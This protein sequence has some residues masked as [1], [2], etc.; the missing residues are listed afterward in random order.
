MAHLTPPATCLI[1]AI[2]SAVTLP[3]LH[4]FPQ[5]DPDFDFPNINRLRADLLKG[6]QRASRPVKNHK[7]AVHVDIAFVSVAIASIDS[8]LGSIGLNGILMISWQ[9]EHLRWDQ[10]A[11]GGIHEVSFSSWEIWTPDAIN[12]NSVSTEPTI[13]NDKDRCNIMVMPNGTVFWTPAFQITSN[14]PLDLTDF[15]SDTQMCYINYGMWASTAD[16]VQLHAGVNYK[17][18]DWH[19]RTHVVEMTEWKV[20]DHYLVETNVTE[21]D[22]SLYSGVVMGIKV[23]RNSNML[24]FLLRVPYYLAAVT[25]L[26]VFFL[27]PISSTQRISL[28]M[29]ALMLL[30]AESL[31]VNNVLITGFPGLTVPAILKSL[32]LHAFEIAFNLMI[33]QTA[34]HFIMS[35]KIPS[36]VEKHVTSLTNLISRYRIS[37]LVCCSLFA[38]TLDSD[39]GENG[40]VTNRFNSLTSGVHDLAEGIPDADTEADDAGLAAAFSSSNPTTNAAAKI[41]F[42]LAIVID[43]CLLLQYLLFL[44][45]FHA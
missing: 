34:Y 3:A 15:P 40:S 42:T 44:M 37:Q 28:T 12:W 35:T 27:T 2:I 25:E 4:A 45:I 32:E 19:V 39:F 20:L 29:F 24:H 1:L 26:A 21:L 10:A 11:Y 43:R 14:C 13:R 23:Q 30:Y 16:E 31:M 7:S 41:P 22:G 9:D 33:S 18:L 17:S 38:V 6:Y 8:N 5:V 36:F